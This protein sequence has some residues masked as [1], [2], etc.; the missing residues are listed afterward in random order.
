MQGISVEFRQAINHNTNILLN[1]MVDTMVGSVPAW[2]VDVVNGDWLTKLLLNHV[3]HKCCIFQFVVPASLHFAF[4]IA[5]SLFLGNFVP[6]QSQIFC[7]ALGF[8]S[9]FRKLFATCRCSQKFLV[10]TRWR[11][12]ARVS[13]KSYLKTRIKSLRATSPASD[14]KTTAVRSVHKIWLQ[15]VSFALPMGPV[16]NNA[17]AEWG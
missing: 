7:K 4:E 10:V 11:R 3:V 8:C 1:S 17:P 15:K 6:T 13:F 14:L 5:K 16:T 12:F 2:L 9:V